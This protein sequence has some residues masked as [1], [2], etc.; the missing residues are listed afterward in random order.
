[1][2]RRGGRCNKSYAGAG[3]GGGARSGLATSAPE[4]PL[5]GLSLVTAGPDWRGLA[6]S[7]PEPPLV[8]AGAAGAGAASNA[9]GRGGR[10]AGAAPARPQHSFAAWNGNAMLGRVFGHVERPAALR[11]RLSGVAE[12]GIFAQRPDIVYRAR[13]GG[14][15]DVL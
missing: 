14:R 2:R 6:T 13:A 3:Q 12:V 5:V 1:M 11:R 8:G 7:A 9:H 10:T 15:F 4:P